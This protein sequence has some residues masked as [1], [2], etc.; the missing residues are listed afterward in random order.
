MYFPPK[1]LVRIKCLKKTPKT[2]PK[3]Q[4]AAQ[5]KC[6][7]CVSYHYPCNHNMS[8]FF[9]LAMCF[10]HP[11]GSLQTSRCPWEA[12]SAYSMILMRAQE[13]SKVHW[14]LPL[15]YPRAEER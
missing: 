14:S 5:Y 9:P 2:K 13:A 1:A 11:V 7:A 10:A 4:S 15:G 12:C 6:L 8:K 3:K